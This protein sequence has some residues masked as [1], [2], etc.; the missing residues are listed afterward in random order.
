LDV[1]NRIQCFR[2]WEAIQAEG[3][4]KE[5]V[6]GELS[7]AICASEIF[8]AWDGALIDEDRVLGLEVRTSTIFYFLSVRRTLTNFC[9][10]VIVV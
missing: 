8:Y 9:G 4:F 7:F 2:H 1:S 5:P 10:C 6:I 3:L